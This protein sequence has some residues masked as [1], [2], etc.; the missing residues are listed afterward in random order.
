MAKGIKKSSVKDV[1]PK[2]SSD[3]PKISSSRKKGLSKK[4]RIK[5]ANSKSN[6]DAGVVKG[7]DDNPSDTVYLGHIPSGFGEA[8][9]RK[10]FLQFGDVSK[11]KLFR[12]KKTKGSKGSWR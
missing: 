12:S 5:D 4:V 11:V 6:G 7:R 2:K 10:F 3:S 9:M 1:T 8:E